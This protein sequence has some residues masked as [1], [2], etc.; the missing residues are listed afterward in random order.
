MSHSYSC[1]FQH[2]VFSTKERRR[3]IPADL[4][5]SV[6]GYIGG[7]A[8]QNGMIAMAVGGTQDHVHL[9][10]AI[11]P[12]MPVSKAV[13]LVKAGSSKWFRETHSR[14]FA[15]QEEYGALSVSKSNEK[16]VVSYIRGQ[17]EHH[18]KQDFVEEFKELLRKHGLQFEPSDLD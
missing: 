16:K 11:P 1:N 5:D 7:I 13:Q 4:Q 9:F 12:M 10:L 18:K 15:W 2:I 8:R 17:K 14:L 3:L 6:A